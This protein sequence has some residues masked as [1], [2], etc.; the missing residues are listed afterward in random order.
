MATE[1]GSAGAS[2]GFEAS[3]FYVR[4]ER[5]P[6]IQAM[7][8]HQSTRTHPAVATRVLQPSATIISA[9]LFIGFALLR[10]PFLSHYPVNWDAVQLALGTQSFDLHHHQPH[11]PGYI[12]FIGL[13]RLINFFTHDPN[14]SLTILSIIGGSLAP[15][16]LFLFASRFMSRGYALLTAIMFG[17]SPLVWYYSEV[18]LTYA[19]EVAAGVA[20]LAMAHRSMRRMSLRDLII[21]TLLLSVLGSLRQS[22]ML[23]LVPVWLYVVWQFPWTGRIKATVVMGVS[24]LLWVV[25]LLWLSGGLGPYVKESRALADLIGGQTS[26]LSMNFSG[27]KMNVEFVLAG[28]VLGVNIGLIIVA[29]ALLSGV[30]PLQR[31]RRQEKIFF[32]LWVGPALITFII[33]HTGQLGYIL[34]LLPAL[35]LL[36]GVC[37][38]ALAKQVTVSGSPLRQGL[39]AGGIT[40][41]AVTSTLGFVALPGKAYD[42]VRPGGDIEVSRRAQHLRQYDIAT[43]DAHWKSISDLVR[44]FDPERTVVLTTIG[45]PR[46]SGSFRH[47]SYLLP[48][49][50]VYG[51]GL[52]IEGS[53]GY[54]FTA[55]NGHSDY[56]VEGLSTASPW[57]PISGDWRWIIIPDLE[58][59]S[60]I[61]PTI[62]REPITLE[63][64]T[65]VVIAYAPPRTAF[66]FDVD[67]N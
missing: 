65:Q 53:F 52:D 50:R 42:W 64:G 63:D 45:G 22:A 17:L 19:A 8:V 61:D 28:I 48:E 6:G 67:K 51:L 60:Q 23:F 25:P 54:L 26:I 7:D 11:P 47:M 32:A 18:A 4:V 66:N 58:I 2:N 49:Y 5:T 44:N 10:L 33:G 31:L 59:L 56:S 3:S 36:V 27:L 40:I 55:R 43:S 41:F 39:L 16:L 35:F 12:G 29:V 1:R 20:F 46:V 13:G 37:L 15:A 62:N 38:E 9:L 24:T 34:L 14:L 30:R 21:A 57:L